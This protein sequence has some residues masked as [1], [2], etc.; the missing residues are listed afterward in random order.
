MEEVSFKVGLQPNITTV[1]F[2][3]TCFPGLPKE[4]LPGK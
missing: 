4:K 3:L 2:V 1:F